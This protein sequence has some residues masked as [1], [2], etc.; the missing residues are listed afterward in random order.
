MQEQRVANTT[1]NEIQLRL[2]MVKLVSS[3]LEDTEE[4]NAE[5]A[6]EI[7]RLC[8]EDSYFKDSPLLLDS[9]QTLGYMEAVRNNLSLLCSVDM[10]QGSAPL[11]FLADMNMIL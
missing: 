7:H 8:K 2:D 9:I 3:K 10:A 6:E 1:M 5:A 11:S 4:K